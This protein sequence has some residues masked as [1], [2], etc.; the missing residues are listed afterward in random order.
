M[1]KLERRLIVMRHAK[2]SWDSPSDSD[3]QRPL[4]DRGRRDAPRVAKHLASI[5][6]QPQHVLSS[7]AERTRETASLLLR[8]WEDGVAAEF[9]ENLY[10]AG[11]QELETE[12]GAISEEV[13]TLLVLGHNP[14]WEHIVH[15]LTGESVVMKTSAA[16]LLNGMC[17]SWGEAFQTSWNLT[18]IVYPRELG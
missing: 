8:E 18:A 3:H 7:D 13:D 5:G 11:A 4:N 17:E 1:D 14:G 9:S 10:L 16:A 15:R 12:L 6:W 2:S